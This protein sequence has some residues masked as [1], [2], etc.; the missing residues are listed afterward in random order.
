MTIN[1]LVPVPIQRLLQLLLTWKETLCLFFYI[2]FSG[3]K[4]YEKNLR[5]IRTG[6][7][8]SAFSE[9]LI[10]FGRLKNGLLASGCLL[11]CARAVD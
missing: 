6:E 11:D 4:N 1:V 9:R 2:N 8:F 5:D 3:Q 10:D 7:N